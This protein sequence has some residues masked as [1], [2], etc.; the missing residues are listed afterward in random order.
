MQK[1][2]AETKSRTSV[3]DLAV[4]LPYKREL[5]PY[6]SINSRNSIL[7]NSPKTHLGS[8]FIFICTLYPD[9]DTFFFQ[10]FLDF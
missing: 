5:I 4:G 6:H 10:I 7:Q 3:T 2:I 1:K 9:L 8:I